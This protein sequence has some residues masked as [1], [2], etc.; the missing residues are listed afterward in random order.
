MNFGIRW[1]LVLYSRYIALLQHHLASHK[2]VLEKIR[3]E[4][5]SLLKVLSADKKRFVIENEIGDLCLGVIP[6]FFRKSNSRSL[7]HTSGASFSNFF[8][9]HQIT[10]VVEHI[11]KF[12]LKDLEKDKS[13]IKRALLSTANINSWEDFAKKFKFPKY[14]PPSPNEY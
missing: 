7:F 14:F 1:E 2:N 9:S 12:T 3:S 10:N 4:R 13:F 5:G 8:E 6:Y 11:N